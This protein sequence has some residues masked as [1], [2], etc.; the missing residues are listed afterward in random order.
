MV[1]AEEQS[2]PFARTYPNVFYESSIVASLNY[3][4]GYGRYGERSASPYPPE[5]QAVIASAKAQR[6]TA[7]AI[8]NVAREVANISRKRPSIEALRPSLAPYLA[9]AVGQTALAVAI[10]VAILVR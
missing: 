3:G 2:D 6:A 5:V 10:V 7:A 9:I 4:E 8:S 1:D